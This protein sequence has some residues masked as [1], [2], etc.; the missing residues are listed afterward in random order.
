MAFLVGPVQKKCMSHVQITRWAHCQRQV[1]FLYIVSLLI[2]YR[3]KERTEKIVSSLGLKIPP[4]DAR[5]NDPRVQLQ[6]ICSQWL[7]LNKAVL[8]MWSPLDINPTSH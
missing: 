8:G 6:A 5:H 4:R 7:P 1:A 2:V 3:D